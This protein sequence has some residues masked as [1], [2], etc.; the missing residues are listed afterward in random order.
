LRLRRGYLIF[1]ALMLA[2]GVGLLGFVEGAWI[3]VAVLIGGLIFDAF[4]AI[5]QATVMEI[6]AVG[7]AYAGSALGLA[8]MLRE[9]GGIASPA[10]GNSLSRF[11]AQ[12]PFLFWAGLALVAALIFWQLPGTFREE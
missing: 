4:M 8:A 2:T 1:A 6:S 9:A 5:Y 7:R 11:G 3:W 12:V 10:I